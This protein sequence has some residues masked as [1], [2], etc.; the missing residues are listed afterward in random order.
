L[1]KVGTVGWSAGGECVGGRGSDVTGWGRLGR[2]GEGRGRE[3]M[4]WGQKQ[5][6]GRRTMDW[7][8]G[9]RSRVKGVRKG[10]RR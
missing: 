4:R 9:E 8:T 7:S 6:L 10:M 5:Y 1:C 2:G 3:W